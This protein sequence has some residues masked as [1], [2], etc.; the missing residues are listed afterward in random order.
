MDDPVFL[1]KPQILEIH[2]LQISCFGGQSGLADEGLLDSA[3]IAPINYY[4]YTH[5]Q[6]LFDLS[7]CYAFHISKN[8]PFIANRAKPYMRLRKINSRRYCDDETGTYFDFHFD[9]TPE[10]AKELIETDLRCFLLNG[11][12]LEN[13]HGTERWVVNLGKRPPRSKS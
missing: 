8:H 4:F 10:K 13:Y 3:I 9:V 5:V 6:N 11:G 2:D 7:A 1:D 12:L